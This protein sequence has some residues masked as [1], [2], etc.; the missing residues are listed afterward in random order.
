MENL[1]IDKSKFTPLS[2]EE[3][4]VEVVVRPSIGYWTV[5]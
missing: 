5:S 3:K 2:A 4:K 1:V